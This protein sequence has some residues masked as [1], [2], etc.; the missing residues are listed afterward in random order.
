MN[1]D[2]CS[3]VCSPNFSSI[4]EVHSKC[5]RGGHCSCRARSELDL[6]CMVYARRCLLN[7]ETDF[8][9]H[10]RADSSPQGGRDWF[11]VELDICRPGAGPAG[12]SITPRMMPLGRIGARAASA[13]RKRRQL[14][15]ILGLESGDLQTTIDRTMSILVDFGAEA[16]LWDAARSI[17]HDRHVSAL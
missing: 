1:Q 12:V 2:R 13:T 8:Y 16:G 7:P 11:L 10:L 5:P 3:W 4:W 15:R 9:V 14:M 6:A 17:G